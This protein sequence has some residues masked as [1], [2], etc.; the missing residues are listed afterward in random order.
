MKYCIKLYYNGPKGGLRIEA[1]ETQSIQLALHVA[2]TMVAAPGSPPLRA[3]VHKR[4]IKSIFN[5][6]PLAVVSI[7][8]GR[9]VTQWANGSMTQEGRPS[10]HNT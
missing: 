8:S 10:C 1:L 9:V 7:E 3:T 6:Y 5:P 4:I 2:H